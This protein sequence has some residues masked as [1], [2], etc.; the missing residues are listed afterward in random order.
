MAEPN[1]G[2]DL[3]SHLSF[4]VVAPEVPSPLL[5]LPLRPDFVAMITPPRGMLAACSLRFNPSSI[6]ARFHA[7]IFAV[8]SFVSMLI[9]AS[10]ADTTTGAL[11]F[12]VNLCAI[13]DYIP[14][15]LQLT[16]KCYG[17]ETIGAI[18]RMRDG[19]KRVRRAKSSI[20]ERRRPKRLRK[21]LQCLCS[22]FQFSPD[23][24]HLTKCVQLPAR[25]LVVSALDRDFQLLQ[26]GRVFH[27]C[28]VAR[29]AP[30][31]QRLNRAT[32]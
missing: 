32:Q 30:F 27:C 5:P 29:V 20:G 18:P 4:S 14:A 22:P 3:H 15:R 19:V 2:P 21:P 7:A 31:A 23:P 13:G 28:Q 25:T 9:A 6:G 24:Q 8:L 11:V 10:R 26:R 12:H 1:I 16:A 17:Q